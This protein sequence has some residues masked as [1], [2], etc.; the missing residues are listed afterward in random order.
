MNRKGDVTITILVIGIIAVCFIA[1]VSFYLAEL[2][3]DD[4]FKGIGKISKVNSNMERYLLC[5]SIARQFSKGE[6]KHYQYYTTIDNRENSLIFL[7]NLLKNHQVSQLSQ[8]KNPWVVT[9]VVLKIIVIKGFPG[10]VTTVTTVT[11][12]FIYI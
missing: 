8:L 5:F 10:S 7:S 3:T 4:N 2:N 6:L 11:A 9:D 1:L 12:V